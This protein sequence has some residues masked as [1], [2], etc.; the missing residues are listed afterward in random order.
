MKLG[1]VAERFLV[2]PWGTPRWQS[3][4][5]RPPRTWLTDL[6]YRAAFSTI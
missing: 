2:M 6:L 1:W 5:M 3:Q 4:H